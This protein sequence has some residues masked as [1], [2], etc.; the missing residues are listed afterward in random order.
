[1]EITNLET[2][3]G[4]LKNSKM[5]TRLETDT[6]NMQGKAKQLKHGLESMTSIRNYYLIA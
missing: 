4:Q 1:M 6:L 5:K 3:A 2:V